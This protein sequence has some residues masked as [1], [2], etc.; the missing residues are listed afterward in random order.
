M[1]IRKFKFKRVISTNDT[2]IRIIKQTNFDSGM[3]ISE[4]QKKRKR[5]IWKKMDIFEGK[6]ICEFFFQYKQYKITNKKIN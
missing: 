5:T 3:V 6:L 4:S 1:R 2:A